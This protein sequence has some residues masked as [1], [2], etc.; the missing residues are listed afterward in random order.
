MALNVLYRP[1]SRAGRALRGRIVSSNGIP[2]PVKD[3]VRSAWRPADLIT[4]MLFTSIAQQDTIHLQGD[5]GPNKPSVQSASSR[6]VQLGNDASW[7]FPSDALQQLRD[8]N[9][10]IGDGKALRETLS[11]Q[12]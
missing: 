7:V 6:R 10:L 11:E 12:G 3:E 4:R 8:S 1:W 2:V 9:H 5:D